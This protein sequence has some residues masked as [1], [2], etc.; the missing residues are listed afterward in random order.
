MSL[1]RLP[2]LVVEKI[3]NQA[4]LEDVAALKKENWNELKKIFP[5]AKLENMYIGKTWM[6]ILHKYGQ[7]CRHWKSVILQSKKLFDTEEKRLMEITPVMDNEGVQLRQMIKEGYMERV[8]KISLNLDREM[9]KKMETLSTIRKAADKSS[10]ETFELFAYH[11]FFCQF[12]RK[13]RSMTRE[14][15]GHW[16]CF[17]DILKLSKKCE[18]V[19]V[20]IG[21]ILHQREAEVFF[22][23][24]LTLLKIGT[25]KHVEFDTQLGFYHVP[26][27]IQGRKFLVPS[28]EINWDFI[29]RRNFGNTKIDH[30]QK[31]LINKAVPDIGWYRSGVFDEHSDGG[32]EYNFDFTYDRSHALT[33]SDF[34]SK[35]YGMLIAT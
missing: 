14:S 19:V 1:P 16:D 35:F 31:V 23:C 29:K 7:V 15:F 20:S 13:T 27:R 28:H 2:D 3:I 26:K 4:A 6:M 30:I 33:L 8:S 25:I 22:D 32:T 11:D 10:I 34:A 24:V 18:N 5:D 21:S 17:I 12:E 9:R